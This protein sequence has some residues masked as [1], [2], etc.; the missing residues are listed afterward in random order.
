MY[1]ILQVNLT[2]GTTY[3]TPHEIHSLNDCGRALALK[4]LKEKVPLKAD[5]FA[6]ENAIAQGAL[7]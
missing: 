1:R 5:Y 7:R 6:V 3:Y 4:L 2:E